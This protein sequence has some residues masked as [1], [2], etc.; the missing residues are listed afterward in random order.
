LETKFPNTMVRSEILPGA[1]LLLTNN[2]L[3]NITSISI[4]PGTWDIAG[5]FTVTLGSSP[6]IQGVEASISTVSNT[7]NIINISSLNFAAGTPANNL[8]LP[9]ALNRIV[10]AATTTLYLVGAVSLTSG[11]VGG[12]G[13]L[14]A[15]RARD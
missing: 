14:L 4:D 9:L 6:V 7:R 1:D 11:T 5:K 8:Q 3:Q 13:Y 12:C 15:I 10:V 2:T